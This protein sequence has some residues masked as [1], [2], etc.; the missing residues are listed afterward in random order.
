MAADRTQRKLTAVLSA[1]V[2]GYSTL[3]GDDEERTVNTITAYR[4][5]FTAVVE[6]NQGRIVDSPGD[7]ILADFGSALDA[8][9]SAVEIQAALATRNAELPKN[10]QMFF[11]IGINL[12]D[13]IHKDG[14]IYGEGVN[15]AARIES[16]ADPG[17]ISISEDIY[18]QVKNKMRRGVAYM[19]A[20]TV[21]NIAEPVRIYRIIPEGEDRGTI[22]EAPATEPTSFLEI[23]KSYLTSKKAVL[24][25]FDAT[26]LKIQQEASKA[27][28][29]TNA[30]EKMITCDPSLTSHV[31][32]IAN[33]TYYK[34]INQVSTVRAAIVRLGSREVANIAILV[35]QKRPFQSKNP[36]INKMMQNLWRHSVGCAVSAQWIANRSGLTAKAQEA[37]TAGL[38]HDIGK[39]L[40]LTTTDEIKRAGTIKQNP[41][42][43]LLGEV[44]D[45]Y[46]TVYGY[47]LLRSW[48]LPD[49]YCSIAR[50]HHKADLDKND[51]LMMMVRLAN[52]TT[53][54]MG[55]GLKGVEPSILAVTPEADYFELSEVDLAELEIKL[56]NAKVFA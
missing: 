10:R 4:K 36:Y 9:T 1:D 38:L 29:D 23:F 27:E 56:E 33:S 8:V 39:L 52:K 55:I 45:N 16:L 5:I 44:M 46:H 17:G 51:D 41:S 42:G 21:K 26:G 31:L 32:R 43:D 48:N 2:K 25:A 20:H 47:A 30:I 34:G 53:N 50:D 49:H 12:G 37:F 35:T 24:P 7:N 13:I 11:R 14:R 54:S 3:M 15:I 22:I 28:P 19:G 18:N 6:K 40:I